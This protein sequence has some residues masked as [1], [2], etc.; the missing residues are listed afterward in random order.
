LNVSSNVSRKKESIVAVAVSSFCI[1]PSIV[2][3]NDCVAISVAST[4]NVSVAVSLSIESAVNVFGVI[5]LTN[6]STVNISVNG[7]SR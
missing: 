7:S 1:N 4:A 5:F 3:L 6:A 2:K